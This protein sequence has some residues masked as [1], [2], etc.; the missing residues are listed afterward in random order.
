MRN[1]TGSRKIT[2]SVG[3]VDGQ[4]LCFFNAD[5]ADQTLTKPPPIAEDNVCKR[6]WNAVPDVVNAD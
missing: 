4:L 3:D 2:V 6:T 5:N 1:D